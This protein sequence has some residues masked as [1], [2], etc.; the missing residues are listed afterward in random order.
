MIIEKIKEIIGRYNPV[1]VNAFEDEIIFFLW[2]VE[3]PICFEKKTGL[4]WFVPEYFERQSRID[5][6]M[7]KEMSLVIDAI[8][9]NSAELLKW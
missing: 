8:E 4:V 1:K 5:N 9:S 7:L 3:V 2:E 6:S